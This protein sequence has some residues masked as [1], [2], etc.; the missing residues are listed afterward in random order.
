VTSA[1]FCWDVADTGDPARRTR[2]LAMYA[3]LGFGIL[4]KA[5]SRPCSWRRRSA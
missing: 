5:S 2:W 4:A 3:L 1:I